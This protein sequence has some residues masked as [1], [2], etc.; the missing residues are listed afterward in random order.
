[1]KDLR[2]PYSLLSIINDLSGPLGEAAKLERTISDKAQ[3]AW[4]SAMGKQGQRAMFLPTQALTRDLGVGTA[5]LGGNLVDESLRR[6]Q[7]S[8]RPLTVLEAAGAERIEIAGENYAAPTF[9][10]ATTSWIDTEGANAPTI[11]PTVGQV[12][13]KPRLASAQLGFSRKVRIQAD[14]AEGAVLNEVQRAVA[15]LIE[16][17]CFTGTG[18]SSQPLG[19]LNTDGIKSKSFSAA[20]PTSDELADML[21]LL[22]DADIDLAKVAYVMH[23]STATDLMKARVDSSSGELILRDF[24]I[25]GLPVFIT[26]AITEDKVL[27]ADFSFLKLVYFGAPQIVVD[28]YREAIK[29]NVHVNL[30]NFM[31]VGVTYKSAFCLGSA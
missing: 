4:Q 23:P 18:T 3:N 29:G 15:Q 21:E 19:L 2:R 5:N 25:H 26:T 11:S 27:A 20:T 16:G 10:T 28:P 30:F 14:D 1:M 22:G 17:A 9:S 24:K 7:E 6:V 31:D 13:F 8:V 12:V